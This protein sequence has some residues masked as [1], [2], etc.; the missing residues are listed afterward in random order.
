MKARQIWI[1][2]AGGPEVLTEREVELGNLAVDEVCIRVQAAGILHADILQRRGKGHPGTP[3]IP[4]PLG[5]EAAG[6]IE[7]VGSGVTDLRVG[8][9]VVAVVHAGGY[10]DFIHV[11]AWRCL[12]GSQRHALKHRAD[13]HLHDCASHLEIPEYPYY[14]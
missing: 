2:Q 8:Q 12:A 10:S 13:S 6:V 11:P 4:F 9:S 5:S 14:Q 1:M 3:K 7:Q